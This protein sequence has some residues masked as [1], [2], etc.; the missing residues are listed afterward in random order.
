MNTLG[1]QASQ[2]ARLKIFYQFMLH[3]LLFF[4]NEQNWSIALKLQ[5]VCMQL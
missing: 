1:G 4:E 3:S 2:L 5:I